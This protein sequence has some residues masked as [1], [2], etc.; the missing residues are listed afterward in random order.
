MTFKLGPGTPRYQPEKKLFLGIFK[1]ID[2]NIRV[3][4]LIRRSIVVGTVGSRQVLPCP[5][6]CRLRV[7]TV[8]DILFA[9][10]LPSWCHDSRLQRSF[11]LILYRACDRNINA[12]QLIRFRFIAGLRWGIL[13][14]GS[15]SSGRHSSR[16]FS[17]AQR[18]LEYGIPLFAFVG[19]RN[20]ITNY[21]PSV[22]IAGEIV[23][24]K[25]CYAERG[26]AKKRSQETSMCH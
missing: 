26:K 1:D 25:F 3:R 5:L 8:F 23:L 20:G 7:R 17:F 19:D 13:W 22:P 4:C 18:Y 14:L 9:A 16:G 6:A 11:A 12:R 2:P 21:R 15:P 10:M 24:A